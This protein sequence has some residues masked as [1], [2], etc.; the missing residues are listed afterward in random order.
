M[1]S[2]GSEE[3]E[4]ELAALEA[5]K[6][7]EAAKAAA[8]AVLAASLLEA[9]EAVEE[10]VEEEKTYFD[11]INADLPASDFELKSFSCNGE[12]CDVETN[13]G[14]TF[15]CLDRD[16]VVDCR[17]IRYAEAPEGALRWKSPVLIKYENE[18]VDATEWG[19]MCAC[20]RCYGVQ[21]E[22]SQEDCLTVNIAVKKEALAN[23]EGVP[24]VYY[25]HGGG[26]NH[27]FNAGERT[28]VNT[29][30]ESA[31]F[32]FEATFVDECAALDKAFDGQYLER[33]W[34]QLGV[35]WHYWDAKPVQAVC[36]A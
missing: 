32:N 15:T 17:G 18:A 1:G 13:L 5:K 11:N 31:V 26:G 7:L 8:K 30:D 16:D 24:L 9:E 34:R 27:G 6:A 10:V 35:N 29:I 23:S 33:T 28:V 4:G 21:Q 20:H 36:E 25:L 22:I 14:V 3:A 19:N 2:S 12:T